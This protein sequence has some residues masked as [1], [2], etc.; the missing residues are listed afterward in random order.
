VW[1]H[2]DR[3]IAVRIDGS[4]E[5]T[6]LALALGEHVVRAALI[7]PLAHLAHHLAEL[8]G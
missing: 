8:R 1:R 6:E 5:L 4:E 7:F 2:A 3:A